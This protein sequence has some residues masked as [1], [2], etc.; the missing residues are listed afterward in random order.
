MAWDGHRVYSPSKPFQAHHSESPSTVRE[1]N[2]EPSITKATCRIV[3]KMGNSGAETPCHG[4]RCSNAAAKGQAANRWHVHHVDSNPASIHSWMAAVCQACTALHMANGSLAPRVPGGKNF[5]NRGHACKIHNGRGMCHA[6]GSNGRD[7]CVHKARRDES[8]VMHH[9]VQPV[10]G[11]G[12]Y[13]E[14]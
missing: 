4:E 6:P 13:G 10:L 1:G 3:E 11:A 2:H 8:A 5:R 9:L 14:P 12:R 7:L